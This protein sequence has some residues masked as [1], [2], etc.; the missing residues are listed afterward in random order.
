MVFGQVG[1]LAQPPLGFSVALV[2]ELR[3]EL[4]KSIY[5]YGGT[6]W[7]VAEAPFR[8]REELIQ[9]QKVFQSIHKHTHLKGPMDKVTSVAIPLALA[10]SCLDGEST[11][12]LMGSERKNEF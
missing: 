7:M 6:K 1:V 3:V 4:L 5:W 11:T 12:C 9:R 8:P 2:E 10:G